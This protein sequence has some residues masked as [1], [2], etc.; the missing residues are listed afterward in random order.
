MKKI[1][2]WKTKKQTKQ[3]NKKQKMLCYPL[4]LPK[5]NMYF[6]HTTH[7]FVDFVQ[8]VSCCVATI[9]HHVRSFNISISMKRE[10]K[11]K[12]RTEDQMQYGESDVFE[13]WEKRKVL[14]ACWISCHSRVSQS[15]TKVSL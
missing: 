15:K 6:T 9:Q 10:E 4:Y 13:E 5:T 12:Q 1:N 3:N 2:I 11:W 14:C 8:E 7:M